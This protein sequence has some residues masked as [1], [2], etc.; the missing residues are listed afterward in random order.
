MDGQQPMSLRMPRPG[1]GLWGV[2]GT[3][4]ALGIFSAFAATWAPG[5]E[6]VFAALVCVLDVAFKEPWRLVTSGLLTSR[7]E[8]SHLLFSL[9]GIYFL[10]APLEK[11][12]GAFR[13]VRFFVIAIVL[14]N[15]ATIGVAAIVPPDAQSRF[16]PDVVFGPTAAIA[17]IA[18]AWSR[19]YR[20]STVN[21]FFVVPVRATTLLWVTI[22]FCALDL[23]YATAIPEGVVA[24]FG[25]IVAGLLFGGSPS[26]LRTLWLRTRL[27][28]MRRRS[29]G[30]RVD[31]LLNPQRP[32]R[33]RPGAP[34]LRVVGGGVDEMLKK[35]TP[36]RD[37]RYLN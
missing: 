29:P 9:A 22:G 36:P 18:V 2:L 32:R 11:R 31:D 1:P 20:E 7:T 33:A 12:W 23:V 19:E 10:G 37:K 35:R 30:L 13:F 3:I 16:H 8:W 27:F 14:G 26:L 21:L 6:R 34:P 24:P 17:A 4:A 15:L 28:F 25:G 5:V